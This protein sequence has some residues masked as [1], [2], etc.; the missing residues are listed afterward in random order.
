M[1]SSAPA[2]TT[3]SVSE[4]VSAARNGFGQ[5]IPEPSLAVGLHDVSFVGGSLRYDS[6]RFERGQAIY[7]ENKET[8]RYSGTITAINNSEVDHPRLLRCFRS[9]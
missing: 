8:G 7:V 2:S 1:K 3:A 9:C 4:S 6:H 5:H